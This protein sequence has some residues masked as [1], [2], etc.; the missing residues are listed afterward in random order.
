MINKNGT[1]LLVRLHKIIYFLNPFFLETFKTIEKKMIFKGSEPKA[2]I[3]L[4][5]DDK[6]KNI[7]DNDIIIHSGIIFSKDFFREHRIN[8]Y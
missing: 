8:K 5:T 3:T 6:K 2:C 4:I 1:T 7:I